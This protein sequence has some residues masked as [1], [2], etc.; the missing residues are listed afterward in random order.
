MLGL[1]SG[2]QEYIKVARDDEMLMELRLKS[3]GLKFEEQ[4][5][6]FLAVP[7]N[8]KCKKKSASDPERVNTRL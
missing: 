1:K 7:A 5:K 2:S 3:R 8:R 6:A 4:I